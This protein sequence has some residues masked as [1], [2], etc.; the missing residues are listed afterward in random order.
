M[1]FS[2][3]LFLKALFSLVFGIVDTINMNLWVDIINEKLF[4][5]NTQNL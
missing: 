5:S 2:N 3:N 1:R 4:I